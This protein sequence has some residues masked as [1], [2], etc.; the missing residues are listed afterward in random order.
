[1]GQKNSFDVTLY[2]HHSM[3]VRDTIFL[4]FLLTCSIGVVG[5][6]FWQMGAWPVLVFCGLELMILFFA[7]YFVH[8]KMKRTERII[9]TNEHI[10]IE[11]QKD[12]KPLKRWE[13]QRPWITIR[14]L[15]RPYAGIMISSNDKS[16]TVGTF[17]L[18]EEKK[19]F[20]ETLRT[21]LRY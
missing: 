21:A 7:F 11:D 15:E 9:L 18:E 8:Q 6:M 17:L 14:S 16:V 3:V 1:M 2:P 5:F 20:I 13:L 4:A 12:S 19:K 10:I